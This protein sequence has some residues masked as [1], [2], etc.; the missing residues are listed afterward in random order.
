MI[1]GVFLAQELRCIGPKNDW[2]CH[3]LKIQGSYTLFKNT[4]LK[5]LHEQFEC[6]TVAG[7]G[8][9]TSFSSLLFIVGRTNDC[10]E[11]KV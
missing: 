1:L 9:E 6:A 8:Y 3:K 10:P 7:H 4:Y 5:E 2:S 11:T